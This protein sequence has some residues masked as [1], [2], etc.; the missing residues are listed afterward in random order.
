MDSTRQAKMGR[1]RGFDADEALDRALLVFWERGYDGASLTDLT[2]AMGISR[3]SMYAAFGDKEALFKAALERYSQGPAAYGAQAL[4]EPTAREVASAFLHGSVRTTTQ[5]GRPAG[6]LQVQGA[7][8]ASTSGRPARDAA[9]QWRNDAYSRL[10]D[11][12]QRAQDEGDLPP[13]ADAGLL[14]RY[15]MAM[16]NGIAVQAAGGAGSDEL[17]RV[18]DAALQNWPPT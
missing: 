3:T 9:T 8:A 10:R 16:G 4:E 13:D 15:V 11:R 6:C 2:D 17:H 5:P 18:A 12:F 14:A 1:P 7:L